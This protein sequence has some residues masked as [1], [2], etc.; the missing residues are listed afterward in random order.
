MRPGNSRLYGYT[1]KDNVKYESGSANIPNGTIK[2]AGTICN[3][4]DENVIA[5]NYLCIF[6]GGK[7]GYIS[8]SNIGNI[9]IEEGPNKPNSNSEA[10]SIEFHDANST[11]KYN[12]Y[13]Y[14]SGWK[15]SKEIYCYSIDPYFCYQT[16]IKEPGWYKVSYITKDNDVVFIY[17]KKGEWIGVSKQYVTKIKKV[18]K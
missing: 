3:I 1:N 9:E 13:V 11:N 12:L 17:N 14:L 18:N 2:K 10:N 4:Y 5:G 6:E 7:E 16:I 15:K 8:K